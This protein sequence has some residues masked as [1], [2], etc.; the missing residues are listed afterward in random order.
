M[1]MPEDESAQPSLTRTETHEAELNKLGRSWFAEVRGQSE[2]EQVE[3]E[4]WLREHNKWMA[5]NRRF[6]G[7]KPD[8]D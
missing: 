3:I 7:V 8:F 1:A 2:Q 4:T 5:F 6:A